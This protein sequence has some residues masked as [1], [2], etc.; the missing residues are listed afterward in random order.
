MQRLPGTPPASYAP[1]SQAKVTAP[2]VKSLKPVRL[3]ELIWMIKEL[4]GKVPVLKKLPGAKRGRFVGNAETGETRIEISYDVFKDP[5]KLVRTL[6]FQSDD[7]H[8]QWAHSSDALM[9]NRETN[10]LENVWRMPIDGTPAQQ[11]TRFA[12]GQ[13]NLYFAWTSDGADLFFRKNEQA[14]RDVLLIKNFR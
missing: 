4:S 7:G 6:E 12:A 11:V 8:F 5:E 10:G 13:L 14:A 2:G 1:K 3:P 9:F